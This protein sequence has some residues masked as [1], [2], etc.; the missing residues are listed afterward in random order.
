M[1]E[2]TPSLQILPDIVD[3][4]KD[5]DDWLSAYR[6][7][8]DE[9]SGRTYEERRAE[10]LRYF[11]ARRPDLAKQAKILDAALDKFHNGEVRYD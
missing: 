2:R 4:Q 5:F 3:R 9:T 10:Y 6:R 1:G 11:E 7:T 8:F